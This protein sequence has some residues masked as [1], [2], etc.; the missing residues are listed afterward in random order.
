MKS[1]EK[2]LLEEIEDGKIQDFEIEEVVVAHPDPHIP[3]FPYFMLSVAILK[4]VFDS[5]DFTGYGAI[6]TTIFSILFAIILF[7]WM[8]GKL[9]F[10]RKKLA[11][12]FIRRIIFVL[13][14]E[15]IPVLKI[16][17]MFT[18]LIFLTHYREKRVVEELFMVLEI[19]H[20]K[21]IIQLR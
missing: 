4:D 6:I 18:I 13:L 16:L 12:W 20:A 1:T 10:L 19:L 11:K 17:P 7:M 14:I 9:G 5:L 2:E 3:E 21:G 8:F 15:L